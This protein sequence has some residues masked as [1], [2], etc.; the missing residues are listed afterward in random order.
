MLSVANSSDT[1]TTG[2]AKCYISQRLVCLA[3]KDLSSLRHLAAV[4]YYAVQRSKE[5]DISYP[6]R[7][8]QG[9]ERRA[10]QREIGLGPGSRN[11]NLGLGDGVA[12][13]KNTVQGLIPG[14]ASGA[15]GAI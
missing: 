4:L 12:G 5:S 7:G 6:R 1:L 3:T 13:H 11:G 15:A 14:E 10:L 9:L 2:S 8:L